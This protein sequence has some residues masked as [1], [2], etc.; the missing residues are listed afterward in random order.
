MVTS[1][2]TVLLNDKDQQLIA[3]DMYQPGINNIQERAFIIDMKTGKLGY[4]LFPAPHY[5]PYGTV[6]LP[7]AAAVHL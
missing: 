3:F 4:Q 6:F 7:G 1:A 5:G 2:S